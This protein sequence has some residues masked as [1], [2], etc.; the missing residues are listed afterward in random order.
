LHDTYCLATLNNGAK[1]I[2]QLTVCFFYVDDCLLIVNLQLFLRVSV[3]AC[4]GWRWR[5]NNLEGDFILIN[6]M[7]MGKLLILSLMRDG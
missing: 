4:H 3:K 6:Y 1:D 7:C 2:L 5:G